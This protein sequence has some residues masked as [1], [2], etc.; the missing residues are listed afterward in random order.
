MVNV[1][2]I[3]NRMRLR[4]LE[5]Y[6]FIM[7]KIPTLRK[8]L[9]KEGN[10]DWRVVVED[11]G[12][13]N[14]FIGSKK[15][16]P[17]DAKRFC[18]EQTKVFSKNPKRL[19]VPM[20]K[21]EINKEGIFSS[22]IYM[23][24]LEALMNKMR[25]GDEEIIKSLKYDSK[26]IPLLLVFGVGLG[27]H[28]HYLINEFNIQHMIV[29]EL[30]PDIF[31]MSLSVVDWQRIY[32][33]FSTKARTFTLIVSDDFSEVKKTLIN[34][35]MYINPGF[36]VFT[37]IFEH[38]THKLYDEIFDWLV[39]EITKQPLTWGFFDDEVWSVEH[40]LANVK[41]NI[42][43]LTRI[44]ELKGRDV[45]VF[46][47]G[48]GP[49]LDKSIEA[50]ER[51]KEKAL[52][53][54]CGSGLTALYKKG[55]VPDIHVEI[56]R[57]KL[58]YD[59]LVEMDRKFLKGITFIGFNNLYPKV[60]KLG[61]KNLMVL[62]AND[63]ASFLFP[64]DIPH[65]YNSN[66]T[67]TALGVALAAYLGLK[68]VYLFGV[69]LGVYDEG[70]HHSKFSAYFSEKSILK[71]IPGTPL[72]YDI[73]VESYNGGH[74]FTNIYLYNTKVS[75]ELN[76]EAFGLNAFSV[77]GIAK[78]KG[79]DY[80]SS[81]NL[82]LER[83]LDKQ[84]VMRRIY[85]SFS[86]SYLKSFKTDRMVHKLKTEF[87]LYTNIAHQVIR[88][89]GY[90]REDLLKVLSELYLIPLDMIANGRTGMYLIE[91]IRGSLSTITKYMIGGVFSEEKPQ[92][93]V[94]FSYQLLDNFF[95]EALHRVKEIKT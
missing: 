50:I 67:V 26:N 49:S 7:E 27:Y 68:D 21:L 34:K 6:E 11:D 23:K 90:S 48:A 33:Y 2:E 45:P 32:D 16:Y 19:I 53:I 25:F 70:Y 62:K 60:F 80:L 44:M 77:D 54:S 85:A 36:H 9:Q 56:E 73:K 24:Y 69:D 10:L 12:S 95:K 14:A 4:F 63:T 91:L 5:N 30:N 1:R 72:E 81:E 38:F 51:N 86:T 28:L 41:N 47:V 88:R 3:E 84:D 78:I 79:A 93:F 39:K 74:A 64:K 31:R 35:L 76:I 66:P 52:I 75:I 82:S 13:I 42:P 57:L 46:V 87:E 22:S 40:T 15:L 89:A 83:V 92:E 17:Y 55:I 8:K 29:I 18:E 71:K 20:P 61:K 37:F 58:T 43:L 65:I 94:A 59:Y